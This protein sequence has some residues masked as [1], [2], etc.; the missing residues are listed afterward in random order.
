MKTATYKGEQYN[1]ISEDRN[2]VTLEGIDGF[3][4]KVQLEEVILS[5]V[6]E[7]N[8]DSSVPEEKMLDTLPEEPLENSPAPD[9]T[10]FE[11]N[12]TSPKA[13]QLQQQIAKLQGQLAQ[14]QEKL[15]KDQEQ[16]NKLIQKQQSSVIGE[17]MDKAPTTMPADEWDK[18]KE[19]GVDV[20]PIKP[21]DV[22]S[23]NK[24]IMKSALEGLREKFKTIL[25]EIEGVMDPEEDKEEYH[26]E[27]PRAEADFRHHEGEIGVYDSEEESESELEEELLQNILA[28]DVDVDYTTDKEKVIALARSLGGSL[29]DQT[30]HTMS[31]TFEWQDPTGEYETSYES[32]V[33][34]V[35]DIPGVTK[36][37]IDAIHIDDEEDVFTEEGVASVAGAGCADGTV[38]PAVNATQGIAGY[39]SRLGVGLQKRIEKLEESL[40]KAPE[41]QLNESLAAN[42]NRHLIADRIEDKYEPLNEAEGCS[43]T[44][45][46]N[47]RRKAIGRNATLAQCAKYIAEN[48]YCCQEGC[49]KPRA[50]KLDE[51]KLFNE[52]KL[53]SNRLLRRVRK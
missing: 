30:E 16:T 21:S 25:N 15:A 48:Q 44:A 23:D 46:L 53:E 11:Q 9:K 50:N 20:D 8:L 6:E 34:Q 14:E 26:V 18:Y 40:F 12:V 7:D 45:R 29:S 35:K 33:D 5:E 47:E 31:F 52:L 24:D 42:I 3:R 17:D 37:N 19:Q 38:N 22:K 28:V 27:N 32:F 39:P 1:V 49:Y 41:F 36:T 43:K 10:F 2:I 4:K 51:A 13:A